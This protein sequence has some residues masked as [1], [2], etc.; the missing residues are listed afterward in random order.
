MHPL[1]THF[2]AHLPEYH[3]AYF[4]GFCLRTGDRNRYLPKW[5]ETEAAKGLAALCITLG[6][7]PF[8]K[9]MQSIANIPIGDLESLEAEM[10]SGWER[11][12]IRDYIDKN[13]E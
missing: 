8:E 5:R 7:R 13:S 2:F 10:P 4:A 1:V 12:S 3:Q 6:E 11:A 9:I